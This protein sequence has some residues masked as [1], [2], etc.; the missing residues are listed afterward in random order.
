M[1]SLNINSTDMNSLNINNNN[2]NTLHFKSSS[3]YGKHNKTNFN[4]NNNTNTNNQDYYDNEIFNISNKTKDK[5]YSYVYSPIKKEDRNH[6]QTYNKKKININQIN[7]SNTKENKSSSSTLPKCNTNTNNHINTN[8]KD[9]II[10]QI[11]TN[12]ISSYQVTLCNSSNHSNNHNHNHINDSNINSQTQFKEET[13]KSILEETRREFKSKSKSKEK[14]LNTHNASNADNADKENNTNNPI[15]HPSL[16]VIICTNSNNPNKKKN[17]NH[18]KPDNSKGIILNKRV[19]IKSEYKIIRKYCDFKKSSILGPNFFKN[20]RKRLFDSNE[21][22]YDY[23]NTS[24]NSNCSTIKFNLSNKN[25]NRSN[26]TNTNHNHNCNKQNSPIKKTN[27]LLTY[28]LNCTHTNTNIHTNTNSNNYSNTNTH[29]HD[30]TNQNNTNTNTNQNSFVNP[31][32]HRRNKSFITTRNNNLNNT[33]STY[34]NNTDKYINLVYNKT[35][36]ENPSLDYY[37]NIENPNKVL[38]DYFNYSC[39][40]IS[41]RNT[42]KDVNEKSKVNKRLDLMDISKRINIKINDFIITNS[43]ECSG[44]RNSR[45]YNNNFNSGSNSS[46]S[47]FKSSIKNVYGSR[48][49]KMNSGILPKNQGF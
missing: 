31:I 14:I 24:K 18:K 48:F 43:N 9:N 28:R 33:N 26:T 47:S 20:Y 46:T 38:Q 8:K 32:Y 23:E 13:I 34:T 7:Q 5:I 25:T 21:Y 19:L 4:I 2:N 39:S 15:S 42:S 16:N 45:G 27:R 1:S 41:S 36:K 44:S 17:N 40:R 6:M 29:T 37:Y 11:N 35:K 12:P 49:T 30:N 10:L 3:G 22:D